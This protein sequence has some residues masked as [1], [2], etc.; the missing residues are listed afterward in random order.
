MLCLET[1]RPRKPSASPPASLM[2]RGLRALRAVA[3]RDRHALECRLGGKQSVLSESAHAA[4]WFYRRLQSDLKQDSSPE[5]TS[6]ML[7]VES[8]RKMFLQRPDCPQFCTRA[9]SMSHYGSATAVTSPQEVCVGS[10][11]WKVTEDSPSSRNGSDTQVDG[12]LLPFSKSACEF[13]YLRKK[14]E[15]QTWSPVIG[16][17]VLAQSHMKKRIPWYIS[18]IHEKDHCLSSLGEEVRRLSELEVQVQKKDEEILALQEEREALRKQLQGLLKGKGQAVKMQEEYAAADRGRDLEAGGEEEEGLAGED[19]RPAEDGAQGRAGGQAAVPG[20]GDGD[21]LEQGD[22]EEEKEELGDQDSSRRACSLDEAFEE[23]LMAQL[24]EYEQVIQDFQAELES[25]RTRYSLATGAILS[26][27]RQVDFQ[28]SQ[29]QKV[30]TENELLQKELRERKQQLQAMTDKVAVA[31][32]AP[33]SSGVPSFPIPRMEKLNAE[34]QGHPQATPPRPQRPS[35]RRGHPVTWASWLLATSQASPGPRVP[36]FSNIREDK[37]QQEVTGLTEKDNLILRQQV[38]ELEQELAKRERTISEFDAKVSQLQAQLSQSQKLLQRQQ[39]LQ[40]E[41]QSKTEMAQ[42]A[43]QQARVALESAQSR[44]ERLRNKVIQATFSTLGTKT[45]ATEIS[46]NDIL[47][48]LQRIISERTD[49]YNQL[50]QKG[51][52]VPPLQQ[53]EVLSSPS[54]SKKATASK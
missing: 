47:D 43:E 35:G 41:V 31:S 16:S 19:E 38:R 2:E 10:E 5:D 6:F 24:E 7:E 4:G 11:A 20:D 49:Y 15:S 54:K 3:D 1:S 44:L 51:V 46:D 27:Q 52:K 12:H 9:T 30:N 33:R 36:E 18:V 22:L 50:K 39:Q 17:P 48:A 8:L 40:E 14:S 26:L 53:S 21:Q 25:T 34:Q 29:L 23:E 45:F 42:Q 13:H 32:R 28:E 37:K